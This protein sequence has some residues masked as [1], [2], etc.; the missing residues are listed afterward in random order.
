M[1]YVALL[2]GGKD[3]C[4]NLLHC[5]K[6]GHQLVAVAS[7]APEAGKGRPLSLQTHAT[8]NCLP[9]EIDSYLYQTVGQDGISLIADALRVPLH[10]RIIHGHPLEQG[11]EYGAKSPGGIGNVGDETEDLYALLNTVLVRHSS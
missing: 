9:D 4:F 8:Q 11:A 2:S 6:N 3:S 5:K 7:L 10:R 1:K